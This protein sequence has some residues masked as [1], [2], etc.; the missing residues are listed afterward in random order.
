MIE[1][2]IGKIK[3]PLIC[4]LKFK[5]LLMEK[6][7]GGDKLFRLLNKGRK[8]DNN[9]GESWELSDNDTE[10]SFIADG[11]LKD[12]NF[13]EV[14]QCYSRDILGCQYDPTITHFPLLYKF[15]DANEDLLYGGRHCILRV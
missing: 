5:E 12:E 13:R 11:V 9:I 4:P 10:Q 1:N 8:T 7:W 3:A 15:I 14:F 6:I 2:E